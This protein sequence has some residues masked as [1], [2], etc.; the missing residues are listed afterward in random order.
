MKIIYIASLI[1]IILIAIILY[2]YFFSSREGL[3]QKEKIEVAKTVVKH[4][5]IFTDDE[6]DKFSRIRKKNSNPNFTNPIQF[7]KYLK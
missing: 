6:H 1:I 4:K 7:V 5:D 3:T 2:F